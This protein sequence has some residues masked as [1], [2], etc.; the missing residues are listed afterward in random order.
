MHG[1]AFRPGVPALLAA[2]ARAQARAWARAWERRIFFALGLRSILSIILPDALRGKTNC[3]ALL[4][5]APSLS[6]YG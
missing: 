2:R 5:C 6:C 3:Y 4:Q 1:P